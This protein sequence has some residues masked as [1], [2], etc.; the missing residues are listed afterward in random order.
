MAD[1]T[2]RQLTLSGSLATTTLLATQSPSSGAMTKSTFAQVLT[3]VFANLPTTGVT[4][5]SYTSANI[6]VDAYGRI[7][8]AANGSGGGGSGTVTSVAL[9]LPNIFTVSG[10]P[11][12]GSGTL[13]GTLATQSA[14]VV[15]AGPTTGSAAAPTF[16]ALV[17][18]DIPAI[19]E[20]QVTNLTT[21]L[22]AKAPLASPAFTGTPT[23]LKQVF[24]FG[25][26][27]AIT[28]GQKPP[29][30]YVDVAMTAFE[31][32]LTASAGTVTAQIEKSTNGGST[33]T[34]VD[35]VVLSSGLSN[36]KS[37]SAALTAGTLLRV[38]YTAASGCSDP[39]VTLLARNT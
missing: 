38:N 16:R 11:V 4:P 37:I 3:L 17:A 22:A 15:F 25:A 12:T 20:S 35:N 14:N 1:S 32:T 30:H 26:G 18:A 13:T 21:D 6:T 39:V 7:T 34:A 36:T 10:S 9:A 24:R 33:W 19:A 29:A 5:G 23:G 27:G 31:L 8:A 2:L 28:T